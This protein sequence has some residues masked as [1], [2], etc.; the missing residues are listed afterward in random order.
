MSLSKIKSNAMK[1]PNAI[2]VAHALQSGF[3]L[4]ELM[5]GMVIGL[6]VTLVIMQVFS[7]FE[8]DKRTTM[9]NADAQTNGNI[10]LFGITRDIQQ[11]GYGLP[12]TTAGSSHSAYSCNNISRNGALSSLSINQI[13][14]VVITNGATGLGDSIGIRY[15]TNEVGGVPTKV[16]ARTSATLTV[17]NS[18]GCTVNSFALQVMDDP[19]PSVPPVC[20]IQQIQSITTTAPNPTVT[21]Q[22]STKLVDGGYLYCVGT[23]NN[24]VYSVIE[25]PVGSDKYVLN[26]TI[27]TMNGN[28]SITASNVEVAS[29][30]VSLQ[31]VYGVSTDGDNTIDSWQPAT[32]IWASGSLNVTTRNQIK[33]VRI[34]VASRNGLL[35]KNDVTSNAC[36]TMYGDCTNPASVAAIAAGALQVDVSGTSSDWRKYRYRVYE[37][38]IPLRN[39]VWANLK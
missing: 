19:S 24:F 23:L 11:A 33:A 25:S 15:S 37:T 39:L 18:M 8:G 17:D 9:A 31:A 2:K 26:K 10:A 14:A 32:G 22:D 35:E 38:V 21:L 6:L 28:G 13:T 7:V 1:Q 30:V 12:V 34:A 36:L 3:S 16:L 20:S 29:E 5:V 27:N 4:I